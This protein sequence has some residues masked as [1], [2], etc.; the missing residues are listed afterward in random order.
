MVRYSYSGNKKH[1]KKQNHASEYLPYLINELADEIEIVE[2][3]LSRGEEGQVLAANSNGKAQWAEGG[4]SGG[5]IEGIRAHENVV[6]VTGA[7]APE[8]N[9]LYIKMPSEETTYYLNSM[10]T[11]ELVFNSEGYWLFHKFGNNNDTN[12]A[13][14]YGAEGTLDTPW[15]EL[16]WEDLSGNLK[17]A[18]APSP[19]IVS[20]TNYSGFA[21]FGDPV[22]ADGEG[23]VKVIG[24]PNP[25]FREFAC[26][27]RCDEN[28]IA[29]ENIMVNTTGANYTIEYLEPGKYN[30]NFDAP[31][32]GED[33]IILCSSVIRR[34]SSGGTDLAFARVGRAGY[35]A[36]RIEVYSSLAISPTV[37]YWTELTL[38]IRAPA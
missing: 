32:L 2:Q 25:L 36:V 22:V 18:P 31:I 9:G 13:Y 10:R 27:F 38:D 12:A 33:A 23:G 30:L 28:G 8:I 11:I 3:V 34:F 35:S 4:D 19:T 14:Y 6:I 24:N 17:Q 15:A 20:D 21:F 5:G 16:V 1:K 37:D 7:G 26:T 29:I